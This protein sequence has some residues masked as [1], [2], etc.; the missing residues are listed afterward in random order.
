MTLGETMALG[1]RVGAGVFIGTE[2][3]LSANSVA[4]LALLLRAC[5]CREPS[6][7]W[8]WRHTLRRRRSQS[9]NG[10]RPLRTDGIPAFVCGVKLYR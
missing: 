2:G 7:C 4:H 8:R 3:Q 6:G 1:G 10:L 9:R 5:A